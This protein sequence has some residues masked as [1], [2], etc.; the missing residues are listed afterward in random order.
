MKILKLLE[1]PET[2]S[3]DIDDPALTKKRRELIKKKTFLVCIYK[4]WYAKII[5][6]LTEK[7]HVLELGSGGGFL[8]EHIPGLI[9]SEVIETEGVD[10]VVDACQMPF[11]NASLDA[12]VMTDVFHHIPDIEKFLSEAVRVL[13]HG[14]K[15]VM[16]EPWLSSWSKWIYSNLHSE[17]F[18]VT[19]GWRLAD[20]KGPLSSAN[21]ALP[22]IVFERDLK[23]LNL[24]Y[25]EVVN[26]NIELMMPFS[27]LISGGVSMRSLLPGLLY[28][29]VR[30]L[31]GCLNQKKWAMFAYI[32]IEIVK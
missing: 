25:P 12:I 18:E 21:G 11:D 3:L 20:Y 29:L 19:G 10:R 9:T 8:S 7:G 13:K 17:P 14:G 4:E 16:I 2:R 22:W 31:E 30:F 24:T 5:K 28:K 6:G 26:K 1:H 32:E 15:L 27:Y 23:K